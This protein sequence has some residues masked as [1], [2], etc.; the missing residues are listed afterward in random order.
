MA[1]EME[2]MAGDLTGRTLGQYEIGQQLGQGGMATV[3]LACQKSIGRTVAIKVMPQHF[4]HDPS[5][6][7]RFEH[8]VKVIAA[9]QHPRVLPVYD[10]GQIENRPYIVMAYMS[11]GT[12][13]DLI[14]K[15]PLSLDQ[16]A[17]LTDQISEGLGHAHRK[18]I[19]HR[20]FKPSNILLDEN[21]NAYLADFGIA[22]VSESTAQLTGS[23]IIG[24]PS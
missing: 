5:F 11:G 6:L 8:E 7:Q 2:Y 3:Y 16:V 18:G 21:G 23:G 13:A 17:K 20:D 14:Y 24:T 12:L 15:G 1:G 9:L 10:Y 19:I 22:K 4:L